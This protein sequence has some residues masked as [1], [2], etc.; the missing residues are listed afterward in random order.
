M[1][2]VSAPASLPPAAASPRKHASVR[3][4][5]KPTCFAPFRDDTQLVAFRYDETVA[6][7]PPIPIPPP[8]SP[9]RPPPPRPSSCVAVSTSAAGR[10]PPP[11]PAPPSEQHPALRTIT[12]PRTFED[13][14]NRYSGHAP[15]TSSSCSY[16]Y[17]DD[18]S[19]D[20]DPFAYERIDTV[21][22]VRPLRLKT[23]SLAPSVDSEPRTPRLSSA[24]SA[25]SSPAFSEGGNTESPASP[26][27]PPP[28]F[29]KRLERPFSLRPR[30][31]KTSLSS[32]S[33]SMRRLRKKSP[34]GP[35]GATPPGTES[36]APGLPLPLR[37]PQRAQSQNQ[38]PTQGGHSTPPALL[39]SWRAA[40][41]DYRAHAQ[42]AAAHAPAGAH[43]QSAAGGS[44]SGSYHAHGSSFHSLTSIEDPIPSPVI[45]TTIPTESFLEDD[46]KKL[47]FSKRGSILFG[48]KRPRKS[49][50]TMADTVDLPKVRETRAFPLVPAAKKSQAVP[51]PDSSQLAYEER[52]SLHAVNEPHAATTV[53][54]ELDTDVLPEAVAHLHTPT[55]R[56]QPPSIRLISAEAEKESQKVRSLYESGD[57]LNWEEGGGQSHSERL[58]PAEEVPSD[59]VETDAPDDLV[60]HHTPTSDSTS[61]LPDS[62]LRRYELAGGIEDWEGVDGQDVDRYGFI[63]PLRP[64]T[65][66]GT[67]E[68]QS[69][70]FSTR[71]QRNVLVKR[72]SPF[73]SLSVRRGPSK[74]VSA[75]S[76]HTQASE[77]STASRRSNRS[78]VLRQAGNML[79]FNRDRRLMDEAGDILATDPGMTSFAEEE[80]I[81]KAAAE[82]KRKEPK[83]IEKWRNMAQVIKPGEEG[84]GTIFEFDMS[85]PKLV[86]RTWKGIPDCW[87]S[88]AWYSFLASSAKNSQKLFITDEELKAEFHR[89]IEEPSVEDTQIDLDVPRT[90]SQHI[91]FRRRYRGG[92]RLLFRVLHAMS[93]YFPETGYV[94]GMATLAATFLSYYDEEACFVMLVRLWEHRG[95]NR[96][97]SA[98]FGELMDALKDFETHW[99]ADK[100][101]APKLEELCIGTTDYALR[102]YLTL[103]NL[104]LPFPVQLR[105]W[106]VFILLGSTPPEERPSSDGEGRITSDEPTSKGLEV[107]HATSLAVIDTLQDMLLDSDFDNAM[108]VLTSFIPIKDEQR[109]LEVVHAE[110]KKH[111]NKQKRKA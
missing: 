52:G 67:S 55:T 51:T 97:Y 11:R 21:P 27:T 22:E 90:I 88:A 37:L 44:G 23:R 7:E 61:S 70:K 40:P 1:L 64:G 41:K 6:G 8:R 106:D 58:K 29:G 59:V 13:V 98:G 33:M 74:K 80:A 53:P 105:V 66:P 19:S 39:N 86:K 54:A 84:Q 75:R 32:S 56:L 104:S 30:S 111:H 99:L 109:F 14:V 31:S 12:T 47:A 28:Q 85:H 4:R 15:T 100:E 92:Q 43:Q 79:P 91:M 9:L 108:K 93:L 50:K 20:E 87:R 35:N 24:E 69:I 60:G 82:L 72:D 48:G 96:I 38:N 73:H 34:C 26:V 83:R 42:T 25:G 77:L 81:D 57:G 10:T 3:H 62:T 71:K 36:V 102:W 101:V 65:R 94:Q 68:A 16:T 76:L 45:S 46:L 2:V 89:L 110:W 49:S 103:F 18:N 107:L 17:Y 63:S 78:I 5:S 95:L